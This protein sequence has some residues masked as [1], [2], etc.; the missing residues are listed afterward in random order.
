ME[1]QLN[2]YNQIDSFTD[3]IAGTFLITFLFTFFITYI[4]LSIFRVIYLWKLFTKAGKPGWAALIPFYNTWVLLEITDFPGWLSLL[5][6]IPYIGTVAVII[7]NI[8]IAIKLPEKFGKESTFAIGL[9][10]LPIIFYS[11]LA[12]D[13]SEYISNK[14]EQ[15]VEVEKLE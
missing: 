11:I 1:T 4:L 10:L 2:T 6:L 14:D 7:I 8:M 9:I 3:V 5:V 12:F 13:K 15:P